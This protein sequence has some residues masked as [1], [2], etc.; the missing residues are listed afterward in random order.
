MRARSL[1]FSLVL[2]ITACGSVDTDEV[3]APRKP[4]GGS[5]GA[6]GTGAVTFSGT[7]QPILLDYCSKCH[8]ASSVTGGLDV[9]SYQAII[10][11]GVV[12]PGDPDA[13][14]MV[15]YLEGGVMPPPGNPRPSDSE[16]AAIRAWVAAGA[17]N[18]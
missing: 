6:G 10:A 15:Q 11:A 14:L 1:V 4:A 18:D 9:T 17:P 16:I 8:N 5:V 7:V 3:L 13:S 2:G 12:Q